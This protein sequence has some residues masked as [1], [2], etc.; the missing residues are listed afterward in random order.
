M[1][2][3]GQDGWGFRDLIFLK[4]I[5]RLSFEM[6]MVMSIKSLGGHK[7]DDCS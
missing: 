5:V 3:S 1:G 6:G 2:E 4:V 7:Y